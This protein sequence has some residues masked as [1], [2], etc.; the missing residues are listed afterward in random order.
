[1]GTME[2]ALAAWEA[3]KPY[4]LGGCGVALI[5]LLFCALAWG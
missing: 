1:M 4:A 2:L 3:A 5:V